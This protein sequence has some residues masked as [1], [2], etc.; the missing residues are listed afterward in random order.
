MKPGTIAGL[1]F[2]RKDVSEN[3]KVEHLFRHEYG[4]IV[5]LLTGRYSSRHI[6]LIEDAVQDALLKAMQMWGYQN[7]P[8]NPSAWLY[9]V[10]N[11][12]VI[13]QLRRSKKAVD[14]ETVS[15]VSEK[16]DFDPALTAELADDQ[17]KMI[18]ACCHP[19]LSESQQ[20]M[21]SLK[22]LGGLSVREI[23]RGFIKKEASVK[24]TITRAKAL[25]R[26]RIGHLSVPAGEDLK[27]RIDAVLK[28]LYLMFNEGYKATD[29]ELLTKHEICQE[30]I[31][32]GGILQS[33]QHCDTPEV[34]ALMALMCLNASRLDARTDADGN[35]C[36]LENQDRS[37][38]N[39]EFVDW[40]LRFLKKSASGEQLSQ[41]HLEA[42]IAGLY[43]TAS[44][45]AET[46]WNAIL[47]L[48]DNLVKLNP[49]PFVRLN[50]IVVFSKV[51]G[52]ESALR[53]LGST[54]SPALKKHH[55][56]YTIRA[57]L[58]AENGSKPDAIEDLRRATDLSENA[59]EK[60]FLEKKLNRLMRQ[61]AG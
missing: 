58:K 44:S 6:E 17:L 21:L 48:Y 52:A 20:I 37:R 38:W 61:S 28:V 9:R 57:D 41:Y 13:D 47:E 40:G 39:A 10:A 8:E 29:G 54:N 42:G 55:L 31:R 60:R 33:N 22:L 50:R 56:Y 32:L 1:F 30:A 14:P 23:A 2:W 24:R 49:S 51:H 19:E 7:P 35:L 18:F 59:V 3:Q 46:D 15:A 34:N 36:T 53:E 12:R 11:N 45:F 43:A 4:K 16:E 25:F 27:P 26:E 5:S